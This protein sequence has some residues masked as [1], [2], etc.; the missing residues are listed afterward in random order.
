M[1]VFSDTGV[2]SSE[3]SVPSVKRWSGETGSTFLLL[4][5]SRIS[6][7]PVVT[8]GLLLLLLLLLDMS[9]EVVL[10]VHTYSVNQRQIK[11]GCNARVQV[12]YN[13]SHDAD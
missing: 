1:I 11:Q 3:Y 10:S 2:L 12:R 4:V 8:N 9:S 13:G 7:L 6:A 5:A